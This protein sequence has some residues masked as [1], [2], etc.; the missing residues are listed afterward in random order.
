MSFKT[1]FGKIWYE[2]SQEAKYEWQSTGGSDDFEPK[3]SLIPLLFGT[4]KGTFYALIFAIP[5]G[6]LAAFY[7]SQFLEP[8]LKN[9]IKPMMEIMASLPSVV[10][11]FL[12]ALF[13]APL[14]ENRVPSLI[15][16]LIAIPGVS[17]LLGMLWSNLPTE[18]RKK[19]MGYEFAIILPILFVAGWLSWELGP[20]LEKIVFTTTDPGTGTKVADFKLWW[21]WATHSKYEQR[22]SL[23][24]GFMMGF[25]VMPIL[26]TIAEDALSNVPD[27]LKSASLALGA[28]RWQTAYHVILPTAFAGIFSAVMIAFGRAVGE[29]MIV[30]MATGNTPIMDW[31]IF[32]G[33]RTLSANIA[34][35]LSEAPEGGTLY[36]TLFLGALLLFAITFIVNTFAEIMRQRLREKFKNV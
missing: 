24:I 2:G 34:V 5:I 3:F 11:G 31:S 32:N 29:T 12:A 35:E 4:L 6:I 13:I 17:I 33:M 1:L 9:I 36:R 8:K 7:T 30:V 26:F 22:N 14:F 19:T 25:A 20:V 28:S 21:E 27:S 23:I 15:L 16:I 10:L 18:F